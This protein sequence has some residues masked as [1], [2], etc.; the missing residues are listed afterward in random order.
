MTQGEVEAILWPV[1]EARDLAVDRVYET[2][3]RLRDL[4]AT[5]PQLG[6]VLG[7]TP[8]AVQQKYRP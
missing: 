5:W 2:V 7:T 4:G 6:N 1:L 8:Q 3:H